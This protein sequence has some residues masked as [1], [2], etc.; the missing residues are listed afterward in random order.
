MNHKM[1]TA[2][3]R[4]MTYNI[5]TNKVDAGMKSPD[6]AHL[7]KQ[8]LKMIQGQEVLCEIVEIKERFV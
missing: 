2:D 7:R 5:K 4:L 3:Y 6:I 8:A 1:T